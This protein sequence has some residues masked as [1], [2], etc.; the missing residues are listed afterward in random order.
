LVI[1]VSALP[2]HIEDIHPSLWRASQLA[3]QHGKVVATG[4]ANLDAELPGQGWPVAALIELLS[5]QPGI[6]ELRLLAP[7][8]KAVSKRP[9]ALINPTQVPY[10]HGF[11]FSG[12]PATKLLLL[13]GKTSADLLWS[14]EQ[15]LKAAS[16]G[17]VILW[18]QHIRAEALRRLSLHVA[19]SEALLFVIRPLAQTQDASP[20]ALRIAVRPSA[21]GVTLDIV[22]RKGPIGA[23]PFN[24]VLPTPVLMSPFGRS[25]K[26]ARVIERAAP[27]IPHDAT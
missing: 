1:I 13:R 9:I 8:L 19:T 24:V 17:A 20:A 7:A 15:A 3:R 27:L 18:Q 22:K 11:E 14:A 2:K 26:P 25:N 6:G 21:A 12:V 4:C 10:A 23:G 16:C 5:Q